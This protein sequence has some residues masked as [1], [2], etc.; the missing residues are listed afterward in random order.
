MQ[1]LV[2]DLVDVLEEG[3]TLS[4]SD[5]EL[6]FGR[7]T[8]T[9]STSEGTGTP[10]ATTVDLLKVGKLTE[11]G[12]VAQGNVD[13]TV[14]SQSAHGSNGSRLLATT[15]GTGGD[16]ETG[17]LAPVTTRGP[18]TASLVP[19]GFPLGREVTVASGNTEQ[20]GIV[21]KEGVRLGNGVVGLGG[22]VHL[23]QDLI[24]ES[25]GDSAGSKVL[26]RSKLK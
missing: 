10:G 17:I 1:S 13:E 8:G 7:L 6:K 15:E 25:L 19:E 4:L 21:L 12:L 18:D 23:G 5:R 2:V 26:V 24:G 9:I 22:S 20:N 14:V 3:L 11:G 16:E